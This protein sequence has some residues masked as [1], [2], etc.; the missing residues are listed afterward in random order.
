MSWVLWV[1]TKAKKL[2]TISIHIYTL[3]DT[4]IGN[5]VPTKTPKGTSLQPLEANLLKV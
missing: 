4:T 5:Q 3:G 2:A 1:E